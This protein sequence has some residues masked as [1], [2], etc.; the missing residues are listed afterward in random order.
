MFSI[1][2]GTDRLRYAGFS[3]NTNICKFLRK[4]DGTYAV[5]YNGKLSSDSIPEESFESEICERYGFCGREYH[6][7]REQLSRCG[8]CIVDLSSS[9]P[10][11]LAIS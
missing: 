8:K 4:P 11:H 6:D 1:N 7:I 3:M 9:S 2:S 10:T 5:S